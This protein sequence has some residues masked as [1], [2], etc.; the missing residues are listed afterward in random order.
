MPQSSHQGESNE[1]IKG[2]HA[3]APIVVSA[4][5]R[6]SAPASQPNSVGPRW[7]RSQTTQQ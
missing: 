7:L 5:Y 2:P 4:D 1:Q 3:A 6:K